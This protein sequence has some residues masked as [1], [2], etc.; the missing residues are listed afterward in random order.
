MTARRLE[1]TLPQKNKRR[2]YGCNTHV[3]AY[4]SSPDA[5]DATSLSWGLTFVLIPV[6]LVRLCGRIVFHEDS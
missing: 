4:R 5:A 2:D 1:A 6:G 3:D